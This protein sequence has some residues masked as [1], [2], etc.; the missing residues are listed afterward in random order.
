MDLHPH[1]IRSRSATA[2][3]LFLQIPLLLASAPAAALGLGNASVKTTIGDPL[4]IEIPLVDRSASLELDQIRVRQVLGLG[5]QQMGYDLAANAQPFLISVNELPDGLTI[6]VKSPAPLNEPFVSFALELS[7]PGG[8]LY[9]DYNLLVDFPPIAPPTTA[10]AATP[11]QPAR[12]A[13]QQ[14]APADKAY[15]GR[16]WRV[17]PGQSLWRIARQVQPDSS[18]PLDAVM[19]AIHAR[20]PHAF[21]NGDMNRLQAGALLDLPSASDYSAPPASAGRSATTAPGPAVREP[22]AKTADTASPAAHAEETLQG[23]L[24]LSGSPAET[25]GSSAM[26]SR[27]ELDAIKEQ[28][29]KVNRENEQLRQQIQRIETS[30][31]FAVMQEMLQLQEQ[32]IME[33]KAEM[34][35]SAATGTGADSAST[36]PDGINTVAP[37][38]AAPAIVRDTGPSYAT[39][40]LMILAGIAVGVTLSQLQHWWQKRRTAAEPS[41]ESPA[42][43]LDPLTPLWG[44]KLPPP[45]PELDV[46]EAEKSGIAA[47]GG[48]KGGQKSAGSPV[49]PIPD[50]LLEEPQLGDSLEQDSADL[51]AQSSPASDDDLVLDFAAFDQ[52]PK[53]EINLAAAGPAPGA[54]QNGGAESRDTIVKSAISEE[55]GMAAAG[56]EEEDQESAGSPATLSPD[57]LFEELQFD[58]A[59]GQDSVDL[60]AQSSPPSDDDLVLDFAAFD[61]LPA[62]T[63]DLVAAGPAPGAAEN[64]GAESLDADVKSA[65]SEAAV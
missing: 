30:E 46:V 13:A 21:L 52:L 50:S 17:A 19:A 9:R 32:R 5:A 62:D 44:G 58:E 29:D 34:R 22:S 10:V 14:P 16:Q 51:P 18:V 3:A 48:E 7:W 61:P 15:S 6:Q 49:T 59:F 12:P 2:L 45:A 55:S 36:T 31:Y 23:R 26:R 47:A 41:P 43:S 1:L 27:E 40:L 53:N 64:D 57:S 24:R 65:I 54:A 42:F 4:A 28:I 20:N 33:L 11:A 35:T 25:G 56:A 60:R 63:I 39:L 8:T 38:A 37:P